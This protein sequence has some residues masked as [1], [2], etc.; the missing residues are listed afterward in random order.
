MWPDRWVQAKPA[1][2]YHGLPPGPA[3]RSQYAGSIGMRGWTATRRAGVLAA[4]ICTV[5]VGACGN[6]KDES[7]PSTTRAVTTAASEAPMN[8]LVAGDRE[9][10]ASLA[11]AVDEHRA[12]YERLVRTFERARARPGDTRDYLARRT[13]ESVAQLAGPVLADL[14]AASKRMSGAIDAVRT[15]DLRAHLLQVRASY[16]RELVVATALVHSI[17]DQD[18]PRLRRQTREFSVNARRISKNLEK[19]RIYTYLR[20]AVNQAYHP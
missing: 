14:R 6:T 2:R 1:A 7:S 5:A 10:L 12:L 13:A 4:L 11:L 19:L 3:S 9:R 16:R 18:R 17:K 20:Y 8:H 15:K